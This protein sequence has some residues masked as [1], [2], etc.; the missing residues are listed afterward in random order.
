[1]NANEQFHIM[2]GM[3]HFNVI[4]IRWQPP[5]LSTLWGLEGDGEG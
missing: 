4:P 5:I 3:I 1:M 2:Y